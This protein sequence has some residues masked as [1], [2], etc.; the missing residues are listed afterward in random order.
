MDFYLEY[1]LQPLLPYLSVKKLLMFTSCNKF[2]NSK[3]EKYLEDKCKKLYDVDNPRISWRYTLSLLKYGQR[4]IP[5]IVNLCDGN[6][7]TLKCLYNT[8]IYADNDK[9]IPES[10]DY[11]NASIDKYHMEL[12]YYDSCFQLLKSNL[13]LTDTLDD[14]LSSDQKEEYYFGDT[15]FHISK[16]RNNCERH[17][18]IQPLNNK[19]YIGLSN[20][21]FESITSLDIFMY[22]NL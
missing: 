17:F 20:S 5:I 4:E 10:Y 21:L 6:N 8:T 15:S 2:L 12:T 14:Y 11:V 13:E 9:P 16:P 7:V 18:N 19:K 22:T 1:L 3:S